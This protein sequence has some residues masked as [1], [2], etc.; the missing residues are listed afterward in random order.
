MGRL[1]RRQL[2]TGRGRR[3]RPSCCA[4][5]RHPKM[6]EAVVAVLARGAVTD[7]PWGQT[8]GALAKRGLSGQLTVTAD[9]KQ[10][11]IAF[12][13]GAIVGASS[14]LASDAAV[15]IAMTSGLISST[16]VADITRRVATSP[17]RDEID[18]IAEA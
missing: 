18:V 2:D 8:L 13:A 17:H 1:C 9:G 6:V 11:R 10:Y 5:V 7:R 16:Q 12:G 4:R 15:R 14:P 3:R